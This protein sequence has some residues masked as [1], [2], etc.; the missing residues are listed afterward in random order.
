MDKV[1][2]DGDPEINEVEVV[3]RKEPDDCLC[4][5]R[6]FPS[7]WRL[8][9]RLRGFRENVR[10]FI[11]RL[12]FFFFFFFEVE[13]SSRTLILLFMPESVHSSSAR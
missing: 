10:P 4:K 1:E 8:F 7:W 9:P 2:A 12:R 5:V 6:G 13:I 11:S 3:Y